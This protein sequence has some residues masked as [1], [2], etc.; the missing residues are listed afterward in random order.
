MRHY[1]L[2]LEKY[3]L[4]RDELLRELIDHSKKIYELRDRLPIEKLFFDIPESDEVEGRYC[5]VDGGEGLRELLG[6]CVYFI[7]SSGLT[8]T[9]GQM[10]VEQNFIRELDMGILKHD[11]HTKDRVELL[12][13]SMEVSTALKCIEELEPQILFLDGSLFVKATRTPI[14]CREF[15][16]Y[17]RSFKHLLSVCQRK[18]IKLVGVSEDSKSR[19]F[20][21][22]IEATHGVKFPD[23][24]TDPALLQLL[25]VDEHKVYVT[26][27][28][29]SHSENF[30]AL[31]VYIKPTRLS[32][33][34]RVDVP[35][36]ETDF[37][38]II[39]TIV[40][41][42][43]GTRGYGYPLPLYL[44]HLD[45][46]IDKKHT[47]WSVKQLVTHITRKNPILGRALLRERRRETRPSN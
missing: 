1:N 20:K 41:L 26:E 31:T 14:N 8:L 27:K 46:K 36:W 12:R 35:E 32:T 19:I 17:R 6:C 16:E 13:E 45:A 5:F 23:F 47:D 28:F 39:K 18:G 33:P 43:K 37:D 9:R 42:S 29:T 22:F 30:T 3:N 34:L 44:V 24:I 4:K 40:D 38:S 10:K 15:E 21:Q 11:D 25:V 7:K 2:W